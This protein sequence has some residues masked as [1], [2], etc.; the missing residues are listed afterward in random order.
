VPSTASRRSSSCST[1]RIFSP[2]LI[3][4]L[5]KPSA[6]ASVALPNQ[7]HRRGKRLLE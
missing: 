7:R 1:G 4:G 6:P 3:C 2:T 5:E